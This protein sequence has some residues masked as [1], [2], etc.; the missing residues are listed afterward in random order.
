MVLCD[1][2]V[3][4]YAA[5]RDMVDHPRYASWLNAVVDA[6]PP[7][8]VAEIVLS[9]FLRIV[10]NPRAF[11]E[12]TPLAEALEFVEQLRSRPHCVVISPG[13]RHWEI[14]V[15]IC[16]RVGARGNI[17]PDAYLAALAI[18]SGSEWITTDRDYS[19]F[20]GLRWRHPLEA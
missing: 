1:V 7:Y 10:T 13:T 2:N 19:R 12:P 5:R 18:E 20:P 4:I 8:G 9:S 6:A 17:V 11:N 14:F 16:R 15:N 3:L